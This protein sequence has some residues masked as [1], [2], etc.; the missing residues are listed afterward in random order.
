MTSERPEDILNVPVLFGLEQQGHIPTIQR[1][2]GEG[3]SWDEIGREIGWC[4]ETARE[5]YA[6]WLEGRKLK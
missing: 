3:K 6:G 5:W 4:P 1:M 2:L